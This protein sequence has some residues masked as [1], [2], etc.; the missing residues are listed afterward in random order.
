MRR[1]TQGCEA[2]LVHAVA[3][4]IAVSW[5]QSAA[6]TGTVSQGLH[7]VM[8]S[9]AHRTTTFIHQ[10]NHESI[11]CTQLVPVELLASEDRSRSQCYIE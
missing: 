8:P 4:D 1:D 11:C 2:E 10:S 6:G 5:K 7:L 3:C 9:V